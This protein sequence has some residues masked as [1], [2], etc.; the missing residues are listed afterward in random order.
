VT[1]YQGFSEKKGISWRLYIRK[2]FQYNMHNA[3]VFSYEDK[4]THAKN[5]FSN[6]LRL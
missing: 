2:K 3:M 5:E 1:I 6:S 4:K